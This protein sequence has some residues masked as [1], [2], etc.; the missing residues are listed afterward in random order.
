MPTIRMKSDTLNEENLRFE[1]ISAASGVFLN[2]VPK[3]GSHLLRNIVRMFVPVEQQYHAQF[4]Q[5]AHL[6]STLRLSPRVNR[7]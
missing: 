4:I 1:Q 3:C 6:A 7:S 5:W 2:S